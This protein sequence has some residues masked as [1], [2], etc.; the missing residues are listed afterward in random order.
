V[1]GIDA[2]RVVAHM[3]N[4]LTGRD[5]ADSH[6]VGQSMRVDSR[7]VDGHRAV[8]PLGARAAPINAT[9]IPKDRPTLQAS[10]NLRVGTRLDV[11]AV[12]G[13]CGCHALIIP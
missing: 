3:V 5:G 13:V 8:A 7:L 4:Y 6:P 12:V 9:A 2:C 1:L 10:P 11:L